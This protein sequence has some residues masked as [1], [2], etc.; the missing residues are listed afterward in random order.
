MKN[1]FSRW[2]ARYLVAYLVLFWAFGVGAYTPFNGTFYI[3]NN[4]GSTANSIV[5]R[6]S[7]NDSWGISPNTLIDGALQSYT[8]NTT[9]NFFD[10]PPFEIRYNGASYSVNDASLEELSGFNFFLGAED[11]TTKYLEAPITNT[12]REV[13]KGIW[14]FD[15][16]VVHEEYIKP[17]QTAYYTFSWD[18]TEDPNPVLK[19]E[20]QYYDVLGDGWDVELSKTEI[21]LDNENASTDEGNPGQEAT[22]IEETT[23]PVPQI[24]GEEV[25]D[26][27]NDNAPVQWGSTST[28]DDVAKEAAAATIVTIREAS[29]EE[30]K[31]LKQIR[32]LLEEQN[33]TTNGITITDI[34]RIE[35]ASVTMVEAFMDGK[36]DDAED[37][38][39]SVNDDMI[40]FTN[41]TLTAPTVTGGTK[42]DM[43]IPVT[44]N[45]PG[46]SKQYTLNF[47][48]ESWSP[49]NTFMSALNSLLSYLIILLFIKL[50]FNAINDAFN[51]VY[52]YQ[53]GRKWPAS[54]FWEQM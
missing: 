18:P 7:D 31:E 14:T 8:I 43:S 24:D 11:P 33:G 42:M 4:T 39:E 12:M 2:N 5:L 21:T 45:G 41:Q 36:V 34:Q 6:N 51:A 53:Q 46:L 38:H 44:F 17:G 25:A 52:Q 54:Q 19:A 3:K 29:A 23:A 37:L 15:G 35:G 28:G 20:F 22:T 49:F 16:V 13:V 48:P 10:D 32:K 47:D 40:T 50:N 9:H 27:A 30:L 26:D 1:V